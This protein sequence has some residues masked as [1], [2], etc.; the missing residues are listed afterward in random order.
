MIGLKKIGS[1]LVSTVGIAPNKPNSKTASGC[2]ARP[3]ADAPRDGQAEDQAHRLG[4]EVLSKSGTSGK[5][6]SA[7]GGS[8]R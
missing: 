4:I 1:E 6:N 7:R 5:S 8:S 3:G 2:P